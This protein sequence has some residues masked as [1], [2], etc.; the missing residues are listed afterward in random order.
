MAKD[1]DSAPA[2]ETAGGLP[3]LSPSALQ[4]R[5]VAS[6]KSGGSSG[7]SESAH[8]GGATTVTGDKL[9][10]LGAPGLP[11]YFAAAFIGVTST[12]QAAVNTALGRALGA[13]AYGAF[14]AYCIAVSLLVASTA[15]HA[16][17][18]GLPLFAFTR[19]QPMWWELCGGV[20]GAAYMLTAV[21]LTPALGVELFFSLVVVGQLGAS[22]ALDHIGFVGMPVS[23]A[24]PAKLCALFVALA[25]VALAAS[26]GEEDESVGPAGAVTSGLVAAAHI[27]IS[28]SAFATYAVAGAAAG[29]L[30]PLQAAL[31]WRLSAL[32]PHKIQA[33]ALSVMIAGVVAAVAAVSVAIAGTAPPPAVALRAVFT[34]T[35]WWMWGGAACTIANVSGGVVLPARLTSSMY[36]MLLLLGELLASVAL[37]HAGA[38]GL[39]VRP[40]TPLRVGGILCVCAGAVLMNASETCERVARSV[41]RYARSRVGLSSTVFEEVPL[42]EVVLVANTMERGAAADEG[43]TETVA[44]LTASSTPH[45]G[46]KRPSNSLFSVASSATFDAAATE[47]EAV[48]TVAGA[49]NSQRSALAGAAA[50]Y[51]SV[52]SASPRSATAADALS[53]SASVSVASLPFS[54]A[55]S[56]SAAPP[57]PRVPSVTEQRAKWSQPAAL[58]AP[59]LVRASRRDALSSG[60]TQSS[61]VGSADARMRSPSARRNGSRVDV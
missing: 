49:T 21:S 7:S 28:L 10:A 13:P 30:Q 18:R 17:A 24:T 46:E 22:L 36:Y 37:D 9:F 43:A 25:G 6:K 5:L 51:A 35:E 52:A 27:P 29:A 47:T 40:A 2:A 45:R 57:L 19:R 8:H 16:R 39:A 38:L 34:R 58:L 44:L 20:C 11:A 12:A 48:A 32:V 53:S 14:A 23:T 33:V 26:A 50:P 61:T 3:V 54:S 4:H 56:L 1:D 42:D 15:M 60:A 41:W 31:N 55:P 59:G